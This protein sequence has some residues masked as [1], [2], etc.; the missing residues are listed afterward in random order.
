MIANHIWYY[1]SLFS[2]SGLWQTIYSDLIYIY[3]ISDILTKF[4]RNYNAFLPVLLIA[5]RNIIST[6]HKHTLL[7]TF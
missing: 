1:L 2:F 6:P 5:I 3:L 4:S 7:H